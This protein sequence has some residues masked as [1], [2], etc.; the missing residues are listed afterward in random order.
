MRTKKISKMI[1]DAVADEEHS[2]RLSKLIEEISRQRGAK[3]TKEGVQG[4]VNFVREYAEHVPLFLEQASS[5][6]QQMGLAA[7]M[8]QMLQELERYWFEANDL[9]PDHLGLLGITDD[10]Y[11]TLLLLQNLSDYCHS[12]FGRP[13]LQQNLTA[14]NQ[15]IRG[16]IGD[17]VVSI[18]EQRVSITMAN[19]MIQ[20]IVGQITSGGFS[21]PTRPDP[22][23]GNASIDEI[24]NTRLGAMGV[25]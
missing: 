21:L 7:E 12:T 25:V 1:R 20:R 13:L 4:V 16:L 11:A 24:V 10:A 6:A 18:I 19:A 5:A 3:P 15:S 17:P 8:G 23:W 2:E 22:I 9:L 14:A